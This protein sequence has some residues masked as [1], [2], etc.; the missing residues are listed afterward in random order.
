M[1]TAHA[2]ITTVSLNQKTERLPN[3]QR[4]ERQV[5]TSGDISLSTIIPIHVGINESI[6]GHFSSPHKKSTTEGE[7]LSVALCL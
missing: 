2:S 6:Q 3:K 4:A 1:V 5:M 7:R